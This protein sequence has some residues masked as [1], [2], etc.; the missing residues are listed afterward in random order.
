LRW[1]RRQPSRCLQPR[2]SNKK[3]DYK[4][5]PGRAAGPRP[6][7][8]PLIGKGRGVLGQRHQTRNKSKETVSIRLDFS[9][10]SK[11]S[12]VSSMS[13]YNETSVTRC[14]CSSK[15]VSAPHAVGQPG[16]SG[17][18]L[19]QL[20]GRPAGVSTLPESITET[21]RPR[22]RKHL[23]QGYLV[24]SQV[25]EITRSPPSSIYAA[26]KSGRLASGAMEKPD[27]RRS[28][29]RAGLC[30]RQTAASRR[31][32]CGGAAWLTCHAKG[33][34]RPLHRHGN[35]GKRVSRAAKAGSA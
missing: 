27:R 12:E 1:Q 6:P 11:G 26:I 18:L 3:S 21:A 20:A 5:P 33:R 10:L 29:G 15:H 7:Y 2:G 35:A 4:P 30:E 23:P 19:R 8:P 9:C 14:G 32:R 22:R 17:A 13:H 24:A 25:A 16:H 28:R 34:R 31:H